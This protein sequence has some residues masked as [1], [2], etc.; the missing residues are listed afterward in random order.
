MGPRT[1]RDTEVE[2]AIKTFLDSK[3]H[4]LVLAGMFGQ[5]MPD[6]VKWAVDGCRSKNICHTAVAP[7]ARIASQ[8]CTGT[9]SVYGLLYTR[10][11]K[12][13]RRE[14]KFVHEMER[15][16]DSKDHIYVVGDAHLISSSHLKIDSRE[17]GSGRLLDDLMEFV[18]LSSGRRI[19]F[20]GDPYQLTKGRRGSTPLTERT[21]N[22]F[23]VQRVQ[24]E[25]FKCARTPSL[26]LK[27]RRQIADR[28]RTGQF[29]LLNIRLDDAQCVQLSDLPDDIYR[30]VKSCK[31]TLVAF[32][33]KQVNRYNSAI[34]KAY[35]R[36]SSL[37]AQDR[38][39]A[40]SPIEF[41]CGSCSHG[42][43]SIPSGSFG[44]VQDV[45]GEKSVVQPLQGRSKPVTVNFLEVRIRWSNDCVSTSLCNRDFLYAEKPEL[46]KDAW[47]AL[48]VHA[49]TR[50]RN[51]KARQA[52]EKESA[53]SGGEMSQE[54]N[55]EAE[56]GVG[57]Y[58]LF[59]ND[60]YLSAARIRFGYAITVHRAQG[61]RYKSII[62]DLSHLQGGKGYLRWLYTAFSVP[63]ETMYVIHAPQRHLL[64]KTIWQFDKSRL[65]SE[66]QPASLID[67]DPCAPETD[68][69]TEIPADQKELRNLY[70]FVSARI[71]H[72]GG[73]VSQLVHHK[74]QEVYSF[75]L[76]GKGTCT[77]QFYYNAKFRI[78]RISVLK[79]QPPDVSG[80]IRDALASEP[81]FE[82]ALQK[83]LYDALQ[84]K[85]EPHVVRIFAIEHH[86]FQEVYFAECDTGKV[87]F[88]AH[89]KKS[90]AITRI[91]LECHTSAASK[92]KLKF[93][94]QP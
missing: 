47:L 62:A 56:K 28:I 86:E 37:I 67:Y 42:R 5:S 12:Y 32:T 38:V 59:T 21:L 1:V 93:A 4:V 46:D 78:T 20:I 43:C 57:E 92:D 84:A 13:E 50:E 60:S 80:R 27:N 24:L 7:A 89:F 26:L 14:Q 39:V 71:E 17:F 94:L 23:S 70:R 51:S 58:I 19:I 75:E 61:C 40:Y 85:L 68:D 6:V 91:I 2:R 83:E 41:E 69:T 52:C 81:V 49:R 18:G 87:K 54:D 3:K 90:G 64:T 79:S 55:V 35:G 34:R 65:V 25:D 29:N 76:G 48:V 82:T 11:A 74:Y 36:G 33:H 8:Y 66:I 73:R 16:D 44:V 10:E 45:K 77:L 15:N 9:V 30:R 72:L 31:A 88:R 22:K 63:Y 53:N